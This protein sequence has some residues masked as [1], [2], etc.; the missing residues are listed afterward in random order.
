MKLKTLLSAL[1]IMM[2]G[3]VHSQSIEELYAAQNFQEII[4]FE[5]QS[6]ELTMDELYILGY[7]FFQLENDKKAIEMYDKAIQKGLDEDYI[8]L[9]KG[10][11]YR[12]DNQIDKSIKNFRIAISKN[13]K[14]QKNYTELGNVFFSQEKYDSALVYFK[15]ARD[16]EYELGDPY[17]KVPFI[18]HIKGETEKAL[19]EYKNSADLINKNDPRYIDILNYM[20]LLEYEVFQNY[21]NSIDAY[22]KIL[23]IQPEN[24][25]I[26]ANLIKAYYANEN[27]SEG[28][29]LFKKLKREYEKENL[30][31]KFMEYGRVQIDEFLWNEQRVLTF[32]YFDEPEEMLDIM[33]V[34]FLLDKDGET[35]QRKLMT[36]QTLKL[37]DKSPKHLLCERGLDG[38]HFTY[39]HGWPSDDIDFP[40][41]KKAI[42]MVLNKEINPG[43]SSKTNI[44]SDG[45]KKKEKK[46]K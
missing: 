45:K 14:G 24:Y 20:G 37:D 38:T 23:A 44:K 10:L 6:D 16:L 32:R 46:R 12:Y 35:I 26:T 13:P 25:D 21:E 2:F 8:Y 34:I 17:F 7:S 31:E 4:K 1:S 36:E 43:A 27:Y 28:E 40:S 3:L 5:D 29:A 18:F 30:P 42:L 9:F 41:L 19:E 33:Y 39:L 22:S 15:Q 11:A